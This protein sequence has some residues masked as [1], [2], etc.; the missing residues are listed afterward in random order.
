MCIFSLVAV[1]SSM[2]DIFLLHCQ[3]LSRKGFGLAGC[4]F[5]LVA[6]QWVKIYTHYAHHS[7]QIYHCT[8]SLFSMQSRY[9]VALRR[10]TSPNGMLYSEDS[11]YYEVDKLKAV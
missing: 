5:T 11:I 4:W 7:F 3:L 9:A 8:D 1:Y 6:F 2:N 10:L